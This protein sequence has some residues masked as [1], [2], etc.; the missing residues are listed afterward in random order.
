MGKVSFTV[1]YKKTYGP[2]LM[3]R[4]V[5]ESKIFDDLVA[6]GSFVVDRTD[7][8]FERI[9]VSGFEEDLSVGFRLVKERFGHMNCDYLYSMIERRFKQVYLKKVDSPLTNITGS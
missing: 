6:V 2:T 1:E 8:T 4:L 3:T 9:R 5:E 7:H